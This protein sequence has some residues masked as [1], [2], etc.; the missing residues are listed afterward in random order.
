MKWWLISTAEKEKD[1]EQPGVPEV[2]LTEGIAERAAEDSAVGSPDMPSTSSKNGPCET[3]NS[4][5]SSSKKS[6]KYIK[7][8]I[9]YGFV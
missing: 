1:A 2:R 5:R 6:R 8:L 7:E 9:R 3:R 4:D